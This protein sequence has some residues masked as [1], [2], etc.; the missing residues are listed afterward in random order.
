[1]SPGFGDVNLLTPT[2]E[3]PR[4]ILQNIF[5]GAQCVYGLRY[6]L[7]DYRPQPNIR[8]PV[9]ESVFKPLFAGESEEDDTRCNYDIGVVGKDE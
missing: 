1:M 3:T 4:K 8:R 6:G 2:T 9:P 7:H 5:L